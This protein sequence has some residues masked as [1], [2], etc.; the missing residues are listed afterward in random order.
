MEKSKR[1]SLFDCPF[2]IIA[3]L[4]FLLMT[5]F[6]NLKVLQTQLSFPHYLELISTFTSGGKAN[7]CQFLQPI[8][9][10]GFWSEPWHPFLICLFLKSFPLPHHISIP[11]VHEFRVTPLPSPS[12]FQF[13]SPWH[14]NDGVAKKQLT[15]HV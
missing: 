8:P 5:F 10:S 12:E 14:R 9:T 11:I 3:F 6:F 7:V 13:L 15:I 1:F 4:L 2:L